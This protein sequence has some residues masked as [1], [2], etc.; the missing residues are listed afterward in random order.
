MSDTF[1]ATTIVSVRRGAGTQRWEGANGFRAGGD[2]KPD[3]GAIDASKTQEMILH[4]AVTLKLEEEAIAR[5]RVHEPIEVKWADVRGRDIAGPADDQS[6][7]GIGRKSGR[8]IGRDQANIDAF[9]QSIKQIQ[10]RVV[11]ERASVHGRNLNISQY[12]QIDP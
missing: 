2:F 4:C 7:I 10:E 1:H 3:S 8:G 9:T 11:R 12:T 6:Q 5:Q